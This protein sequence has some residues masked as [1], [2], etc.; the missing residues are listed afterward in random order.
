MTKTL[1]CRRCEWKSTDDPVDVTDG[2]TC[3]CHAD[4]AFR[5]PCDVEGGCGPTPHLQELS[6]DAQLALHAIESG[7]SLCI[8]CYR[9]LTDAERQSCERCIASVQSAL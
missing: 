1:R 7:H 5:P 4:G 6:P 8:L 3:A 2:C 9:S